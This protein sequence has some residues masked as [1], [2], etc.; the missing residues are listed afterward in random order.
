[1]RWFAIAVA[2]TLA[3]SVL[4]ITTMVEGSDHHWNGYVLERG[5]ISD[6]VLIDENYDYYSLKKG[7]H[8]VIVVSFIFIQNMPRR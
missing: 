3:L 8:D 4:P 2:A 1:M 7:T 5:A 6:H